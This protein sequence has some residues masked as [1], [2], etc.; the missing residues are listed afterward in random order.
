MIFVFDALK[1]AGFDVSDADWP[2][3][4]VEVLAEQGADGRGA[5]VLRRFLIG[6][7]GHPRR[8]R[9]LEAHLSACQELVRG[10]S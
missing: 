10:F 7:G 2:L 8:V 5:G 9:D 4:A 3:V 1:E 6:V